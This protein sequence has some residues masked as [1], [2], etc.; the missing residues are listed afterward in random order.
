[1]ER[2]KE[3]NKARENKEW[4]K[5]DDLRGEIEKRGWQ[6]EDSGERTVIKKI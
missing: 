3:R 1:M 4:K 5:S 6:I 2:V